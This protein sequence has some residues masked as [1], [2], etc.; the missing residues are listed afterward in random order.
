MPRCSLL[1]SI[2]VSIA[3]LAF[4]Q[5]A[6][7]TNGSSAQTAVA[8]QAPSGIQL[9]DASTNAAPARDAL[10]PAGTIPIANA[11]AVSTSQVNPLPS[12]RQEQFAFD[13]R[14]RLVFMP[15]FNLNGS[16]FGNSAS[17]SG[18][19]GIDTRHLILESLAAYNEAR[20]TNDGTVNNRNGNVRS[21]TASAYYRLSN[22]WFLGTSGGWY[23]LSTTNYTK[24][25]WTMNFGGGSDFIAGGTSF[26]L[27]AGYTP[28]V[29]DHQTGSQ[30]PSFQ[31]ILPSPLA[32]GHVMFVENLDIRFLHDTIT[33]PNDPVLTELEKSHRTHTATLSFGLILRF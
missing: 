33:D 20:K 22:Y 13:R 16:G 32:Q 3:S 1:G 14:P 26:R 15:Q 4:A 19:V 29:F 17:A 23:K 11:I 8:T 30:G 10:P 12:E 18:G 31:F 6:T 9:A 7:S 27:S 25:T 5:N 28:A 24:Q 2:L 21:L